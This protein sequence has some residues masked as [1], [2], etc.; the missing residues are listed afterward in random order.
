LFLLSLR[1]LNEVNQLA[2]EQVET[3]RKQERNK[4]ASA[5]LDQADVIMEQ[6][7]A[8]VPAAAPLLRWFQTERIRIGPM[9]MAKVIEATEVA[10][11]RLESVLNLYLAA[12]PQGRTEGERCDDI[13]MGS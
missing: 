7:I 5:L 11:R 13:D 1:R 3:L 4:T 9:P 12:N 8:I 6:I 10:H 2:L